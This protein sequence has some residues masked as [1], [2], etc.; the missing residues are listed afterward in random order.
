MRVLITDRRY[1]DYSIEQGIMNK[2]G[3]ELVVYDPS[4]DWTQS[5]HSAD[6][7]LVDQ[8]VI[9]ASDLESFQGKVI[10]RY[11][12][13]C[14]NIPLELASEKGIEVIPVLDYCSEEVA[15]HTLAMILSCARQLRKLDQTVR[16]GKWNV[17]TNLPIKRISTCT[18]G[19]VGYG[20][21]GQA[22]CRRGG[23]LFK[24]VLVSPGQNYGGKADTGIRFANLDEIFSQSD[25]VS[26]HV[27]ATK[28]NKFLVNDKLIS[29]MK[30]TAYLINTARGSVIDDRALVEA[31]KERRIAGAALDVYLEEPPF[32]DNPYFVLEN[33][34]LT[35]HS[36]YYSEES[37]RELRKRTAENAVQALNRKNQ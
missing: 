37:F 35:D 34:I 18:L 24:E 4:M 8:L 2:A 26:I 29:L 31:L 10:C 3:L 12:T 1:E 13:G 15:D 27:P 30:K 21:T 6:A 14:D 28:E 17:H 25:F 36:A 32:R 9:T 16:A 33:V 20:K 5:L 11:G 7:L 19:V 23:A 22:L